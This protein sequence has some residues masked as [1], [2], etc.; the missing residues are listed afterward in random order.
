MGGLA[1]LHHQSEQREIRDLCPL[2]AR[3]RLTSPQFRLS[4]TGPHPDPINDAVLSGW[5]AFDELVPLDVA[6]AVHA[7]QA[8]PEPLCHQLKLSAPP[9]LVHGDFKLGNVG[10]D[11]DRLVLIDWGEMTGMAPAEVELTWLA[12]VRCRF[13]TWMPEHVFAAYDE[14][15]RRPLDR[16]TLDLACLGAL[17]QLGCLMTGRCFADDEATRDRG[18]LELGWWVDR[19]RQALSTWSPV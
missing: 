5:R 10:F 12:G 9:T 17:A 19:V 4:D 13:I 6:E 3:Y 14:Q 16:R 2:S 7:V 11:G 18:R 15:A 1:K 8:D